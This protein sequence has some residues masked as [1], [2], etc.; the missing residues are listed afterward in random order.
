MKTTIKKRGSG[1]LPAKSRGLLLHEAFTVEEG[2]NSLKTLIL[3]ATGTVLARSLHERW[4]Y[5]LATNGGV[6]RPFR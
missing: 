6:L 1:I 4:V 3:R 5:I 2:W